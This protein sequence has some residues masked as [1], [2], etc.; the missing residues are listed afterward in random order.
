MKI[1]M[2]QREARCVI[3]ETRPVRRNARAAQNN[4]V[5]FYQ[6]ETHLCNQL[7]RRMSRALR[8]W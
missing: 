8:A 2:T 3:E 5:L 7:A 4:N 1:G 6:N